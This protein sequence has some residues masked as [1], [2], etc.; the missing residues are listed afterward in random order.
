[1]LLRVTTAGSAY[2]EYEHYRSGFRLGS[3]P[4]D[5]AER[6]KLNGWATHHGLRHS[7]E[8]LVRRALELEG[9]QP[10]DVTLSAGSPPMAAT[11]RIRDTESDSEQQTL[12]LRFS[13][14]PCETCRDG[15]TGWWL[16]DSTWE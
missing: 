7:L 13:R 2:W 9:A 10:I 11:V 14:K 8:V 5:A 4:L 12:L 16:W 1:L 3:P 6:V 15:V